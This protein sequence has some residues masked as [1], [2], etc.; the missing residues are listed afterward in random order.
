MFHVSRL[1]PMGAAFFLVFT[2]E[3]SAATFAVFAVFLAPVFDIATGER[4]G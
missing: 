3:P 2:F 1:P 4:D